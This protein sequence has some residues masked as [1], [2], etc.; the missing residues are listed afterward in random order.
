MQHIVEFTKDPGWWFSAV[1]IAILAAVLAAYIKDWFGN[2]LSALSLRYRTRRR[3]KLR[4]SA[5][6]I[7]NIARDPGYMV[8]FA[9]RQTGLMISWLGLVML[10]TLPTS[11]KS[12]RL[13]IVARSVTLL[14]QVFFAF[15]IIGSARELKR[16][17]ARYKRRRNLYDVN[18][19]NA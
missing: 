17:M 4:K 14:M 1:F 9:V 5:L 7:R 3:N 16:G 11:D 15:T 2:F 19:P 10:Y 13:V 8:F 6:T 12:S 18:R